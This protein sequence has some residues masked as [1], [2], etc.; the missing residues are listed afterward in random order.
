MFFLW[1][2][3]K[4]LKTEWKEIDNDDGCEV[5][6]FINCH[7]G[8]FNSIALPIR[9]RKRRLLAHTKEP[10][11][12]WG[13]K[14]ITIRFCFFFCFAEVTQGER[15]GVQNSVCGCQCSSLRGFLPPPA[16]S[17]LCLPVMSTTT[18]TFIETRKK[19]WK[20]KKRIVRY[21]PSEEMLTALHMLFSRLCSLHLY[22]FKR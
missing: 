11:V 1:V 12:V 2:P 14:R 15:R 8:G 20:K 10:Y 6:F 16:C 5:Y 7:E 9:S 3:H 13:P 19:T 22:V 18:V 4:R 17:P 21:W